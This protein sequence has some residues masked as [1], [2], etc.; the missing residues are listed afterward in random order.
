VYPASGSPKK[1]GPPDE[2]LVLPIGPEEKELLMKGEEGAEDVY[3]VE[4]GGRVSQVRVRKQ[5]CRMMENEVGD[6]GS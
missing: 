2:V 4:L 5:D 1:I 6:K 3:W